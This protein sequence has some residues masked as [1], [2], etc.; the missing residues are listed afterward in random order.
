VVSTDGGKTWHPATGTTSWSYKW[1]AQ[2]NPSTKILARATDDSGNI[3]TPSVGVSVNVSCP[4]SI[5]GA[6]TPGGTADSGD[7]NAVSVGVKFK[8]DAFGTVS[9]LRFYKVST[10]TGTHVGSLWDANGKL[11]ASATFTN[12][13]ASGWQQVSLSNPVTIQPNTTYVASYYAPNGHYAA[14]GDYFY[15]APAPGMTGGGT[16]DNAPLHALVNVGN[17]LFTYGANAFPTGSYNNSNYWVDVVFASLPAPGQ[18]SGVSAAPGKGSATVTWSAPTSGGP[19]TSYTITPYLGMTAQT[20]TTVTGSPPATSVTVRNLTPG[21]MYTFTVTAANP[22]GS[23]L[24]SAPSTP[25]TPAPLTAPSPPGGVTATPATTSALVSW[26]TPADDGGTAITGYTITPYVGSVAQT[27]TLVSNPGATSARVTLLTNGTAYTFTVTASNAA[28]TSAESA[29]SSPATPEDTILDFSTPATVDSGDGNNATVGVKFISDL[30]GQVTGVRFYKAAANTGTHIGSLWNAAG[31]LLASAT[32]ANETASGWQVVTFSQPVTIVTNTTYVASYYAP[33]GHYSVTS[34]GFK[35]A[36]D[37]PPLH[38]LANTTSSNG[39]FV[40]GG[41]AFPTGSFNAGNYYVDPLFAPLPPPG[42]VTNVGAT[43]AVGGADLTWSAPAA[44]GPV[45]KYTVTPYIGSTPQAASTV[46]GAPPATGA[47]IRGLTAGTAYT[48]AVTASNVNGA[49]PASAQS[50]SV[51]PIAATPPTAPGAVAATAATGSALVSWTPPASDGGSNITGYTVTP[52]IGSAAQP[53]VQVSDPKATSVNVGGLTNGTAYTFAVAA[54]NGVGTGQAASSSVVTPENAIFD[55]AT[56][57]TVDAGDV[58]S[59][60]L[61]V[62]FTSDVPGA[63]TGIRFYKA[64]ANTGVHVGS[65]W[66]A[67]GNLLATATFMGETATGWQQVTFSQAVAIVPGNIYVASYYAPGGHYSVTSNAFASAVDHAP[68]HA[69]ANTTSANGVFVYGPSS[70]FPNG[71]YNASNYYVDVLFA[72]NPTAT[73]PSAP[74]NVSATP[75]RASAQVTW[76]APSGDGGSP[77][78]GYTITPY[79]GSTAQP[80]THV[81][82]ASTTVATVSNLTNGTP[83]TFTL[84]AVNGVGTGTG[85]APSGA[86]TPQPTIFDFAAPTTIDAGDASGVT[87]GLKFTSDTAGSVTG[88]RFYKAPGNSGAHV[89][90]LWS[91]SGTLLASASFTGETASGWQYVAFA[92]PVAITAGTT[93]VASYFAPNGHYSVNSNAFSAAIDNAP[94]HAVANSTSA[95]GVFSYGSGLAFPNGSYNASNY[96]VDVTFS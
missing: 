33:A 81:G 17:G 32:F 41:N 59:V 38:G 13:T 14:T 64:A 60:T 57:T 48:F 69:V 89:G 83:Y 39:V 6:G 54:V 11:L 67:A 37:N 78:T 8:S 29:P 42:Q 76:S 51:T 19:V 63:V 93:Y 12:E 72:P 53:A 16:V 25:V 88:I 77:I 96:W 18:P 26:T 91:A 43:A 71:S 24:A 82:G 79:H 44:G 15:N 94:L 34:S 22:N 45:T 92:Q 5:W 73:A 66:D 70:A 86:V 46:T 30:A 2:G 62:K 35:S 3:E 58:N 85:S 7:G 36:I 52:Y 90:A 75:A 21:A 74:G 55:F 95:N 56:P 80:A 1:T 40:Y 49:G 65:L 28:G 87:L 47:S 10:N 23:G 61:G 20:S 68:L 27:P 84:A 50:N 9:A 4:C 31:N